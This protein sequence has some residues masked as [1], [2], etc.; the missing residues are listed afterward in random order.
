MLTYTFTDPSIPKYLFLYQQIKK[1]IQNN[2]LTPGEKLPSKRTFAAHLGVSVITI[3]NAYQLLIDEGYVVAKQRS[4]YY[5]HRYEPM[6]ISSDNRK[7]MDIS[8]MSAA[9]LSSVLTKEAD[10]SGAAEDLFIPTQAKNASSLSS[11][12]LSEYQKIMRRVM[13]NH[14]EALT[15]R[16]P[17]FGC[18]NFRAAISKYLADYRGIHVKPQQIVIGSG[19]EQLY[20]CLLMFFGRDKIFG[21]EDPSYE[22]IRQVYEANG[23]VCDMLPM[24]KTGINSEALKHTNA[25][26]LHVTPFHSFPTG[27]TANAQKRMEY[28]NWAYERNGYIIED[29]ID[30][31]FAV[32]QKPVETVFSMDQKHRVIYMNT[33]TKSIAP[34]LRI[35]YLVLPEPMLVSY[36]QKLG[37]HSCTVP[38]FD[39]YVLA[40]FINEGY[41]ERH[42]N[43]LRRSL[44]NEAAHGR[45]RATTSL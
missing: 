13:A 5:V 11:F 9:G 42:L 6:T 33:F 1:D 36:T 43:R 24:D 15:E 38:T 45:S 12:P 40:E 16:S 8:E 29:D 14:P 31:E 20:A 28:L 41:F 4:G 39:Q 26:I 19:S 2:N 3:D 21:L 34:S 25:N 18:D 17:V 30:S 32:G 22:K 37:F 23:G 27:I 44:R 10:V 7:E 35:G